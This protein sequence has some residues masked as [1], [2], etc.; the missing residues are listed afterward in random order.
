MPGW[1][2]ITLAK[3]REYDGAIVALRRVLKLEPPDS[4]KAKLGLEELVAVE[5]T[6]ALLNG[7]TVEATPIER[8]WLA[9]KL[10]WQRRYALS[11]KMYAQA[12]REGTEF[13]ADLRAEHRYDAARSAALADPT[14]HPRA[15]AWLRA[16]L[17]RYRERLPAES[18][19]V[20]KTL[21]DW[22]QHNDLASIRDVADLPSDFQQL[23]AD[24]NAL[25]K[26]ASK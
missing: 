9:E 12:L 24:V 21:L 10:Y 16:N 20:K 7:A 11:A 26:K 17:E 5:Q 8:A 1:L 14:W 3:N 18:E 19:F 25:L 22:K 4:K 2:G 23:W 15:L 6:V 13:A